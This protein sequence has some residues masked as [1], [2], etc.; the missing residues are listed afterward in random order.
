MNAASD[1]Y[2]LGI[3]LYELLT[4]HRPFEAESLPRLL[5]L[6]ATA[7]FTPPSQSRPDRE[8]PE[9]VERICLKAMSLQAEDRYHRLMTLQQGISQEIHEA[10]IG[11][12]LD[13]LVE[14]RSTETDLLLQA[15]TW[16]Q[17]PEIDGITY[18]NEGYAEPGTI[19]RAEIVDSGDYDLVARIL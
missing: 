2:S 18:I 11:R 8:I 4:L 14:G 5:Y 16:G 1:V 13:V 12:Q 3:L 15:R 19:V 6:K 10:M 17:A 9:E 7:E